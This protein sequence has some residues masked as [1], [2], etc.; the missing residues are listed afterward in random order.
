MTRCRPDLTF[1]IGKLSQF[2]TKAL[3]RVYEL[4]ITVLMYVHQTLDLGLD[5]PYE[6]GPVFGTHG[7]LASPRAGQVIRLPFESIYSS[8]VESCVCALGI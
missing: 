4:G 5:F 7:H 6:L 3:K 8:T 2:A 1:S